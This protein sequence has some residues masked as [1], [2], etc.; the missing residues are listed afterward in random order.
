MKTWTW[1]SN[2][3]FRAVA[4]SSVRRYCQ[5]PPLAMGRGLDLATMKKCSVEGCGGTEIVKGL[6]HKHYERKRKTGTTELLI[7]QKREKVI[8]LCI[9]DGCNRK[10]N[11]HGYCWMHWYRLRHF[12]IKNAP[13][14]DKRKCLT[15]GCG[16]MVRAMTKSSGLCRLCYGRKYKIEKQERIKQLGDNWR[17]GHKGSVIKY[18]LKSEYGMTPADLEKMK[19]TQQHRCACCG[20]QRPLKI[21]HCHNTKP[22]HVRG[23]LCNQCNMAA[24]LVGDTPKGAL[25]LY[26]YLSRTS[27]PKHQQK[28]LFD[29][30]Q[31]ELP[32]FTD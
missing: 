22:V 25:D 28:V 17:L 29:Q 16:H 19:E 9:V 31:G 10:H 1:Q 23:L 6:C 5:V 32:C 11:S 2:K 27:A 30:L 20:R 24:G 3:T 21:D 12:G 7:R 26:L 8:R 13:A 15:E 4:P 18:R 14:G